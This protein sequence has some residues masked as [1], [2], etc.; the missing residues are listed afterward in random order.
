ML[1][2]IGGANWANVYFILKCFKCFYIFS[3]SFFN[4]HAQQTFE[5]FSPDHV[6]ET[7]AEKVFSPK[8]LCR[9]QTLLMKLLQVQVS[10][11]PETQKRSLKS[12]FY[13]LIMEYWHLFVLSGD[14]TGRPL[15]CTRLLLHLSP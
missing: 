6:C 13:L 10:C 9:P 4:S 12:L 2:Y 5:D 3:F 14:G 1:R 8:A 11:S 15:Q 7:P